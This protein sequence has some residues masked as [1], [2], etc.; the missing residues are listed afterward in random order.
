[1]ASDGVRCFKG[2]LRPT[3]ITD[4]IRCSRIK[5]G[6]VRFIPEVRLSGIPCAYVV[7]CNAE[8]CNSLGPLTVKRGNDNRSKH[9]NAAGGGEMVGWCNSPWRKE[10]ENAL[11]NVWGKA[12]ESLYV[13]VCVNS[14][15]LE[16]N[17]VQGPLAV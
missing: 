13:C 12:E 4:S 6:K 14:G 16:C 1:M 9:W 8:N 17:G 5:V 15:E 10:L 3:H 2:L 11:V 7:R